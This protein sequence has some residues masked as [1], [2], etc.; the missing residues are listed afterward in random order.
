MVTTG[1]AKPLLT[2]K[3]QFRLAGAGTDSGRTPEQRVI[4]HLP[5]TVTTRRSQSPVRRPITTSGATNSSIEASQAESSDNKFFHASDASQALLA[6]STS[7]RKPAFFTANSF[8]SNTKAVHTTPELR[9]AE[10]AA[11]VRTRSQSRSYT[12]RTPTLR[13]PSPVRPQSFSTAR[14]KLAP[15]AKSGP[16]TPEL[17]STARQFSS[18]GETSDTPSRPGLVPSDR[19]QRQ[20]SAMSLRAGPDPS[21]PVAEKHQE[22]RPILKSPA[23]ERNSHGDR[24]SLLESSPTALDQSRES[25]LLTSPQS[26]A[27]SS[28]SLPKSD[29]FENAMSQP[30]QTNRKIMDLEIRTT[31]LMAVNTHLEKQ[32]RRQATE[33]KE[34]RK[35]IAYLLKN[36]GTQP[37]SLV[38]NLSEDASG[39]EVDED[40]GE[41]DLLEVGQR[42]RQAA[43]VID[44]SI[45]RA[46]LLSEQLLGDANKGLQYR[47]RESEIGIGVRKV[48]VDSTPDVTETVEEEHSSS[49]QET[50]YVVHGDILDDD[51]DISGLDLASQGLA[52]RDEDNDSLLV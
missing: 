45:K 7:T 28:G 34:M 36:P 49:W 40:T 23:K 8:T 50:G 37:A 41:E 19:L 35:R 29:Y 18:N 48:V 1:Q 14:L 12:T 44:L 17:Y 38:E 46:L 26:L 21:R 4:N 31:S 30:A 39:S 32:T 5:S 33:M 20:K 24:M 22:S 16:E 43:T 47:P 27:S 13:D 52:L 11:E 15:T 6:S 10:S 9:R 42:L 3:R 51:R 25:K 2:D